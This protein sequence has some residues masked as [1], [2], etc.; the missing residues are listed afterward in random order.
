M[1]AVS[2]DQSMERK[3]PLDSRGVYEASL[4]NGD[5]TAQ[6]PC[7]VSGYPVMHMCETNAKLAAR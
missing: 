5:G 1:L 2:V 6:P 7:I 4:L 3:L